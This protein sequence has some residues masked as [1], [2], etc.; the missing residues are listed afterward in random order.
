MTN[1]LHN[2]SLS[3]GEGDVSS[4]FVLNELDLDLAPLTASLLVIVVIIISCGGDTRTLGAAGLAV[5]GRVVNGRTVVELRWISDVG[6]IKGLD[7]VL[8]RVG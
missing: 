4:G 2:A 1:L 7:F 6:H 3:L 5:A 8:D